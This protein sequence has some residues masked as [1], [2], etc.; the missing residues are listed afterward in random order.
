MLLL[1]G[2]TSTS[3][4]I[5]PLQSDAWLASAVHDV[6]PMLCLN[7][8]QARAR[9]CPLQGRAASPA[10]DDGILSFL[11]AQCVEVAS[12]WGGV[13]FVNPCVIITHSCLC[14]PRPDLGWVR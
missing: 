10:W 4:R 9:D 5:A 14:G 3:E 6:T 8:A 11:A 7:R 12:S 1:T 2:L 13:P